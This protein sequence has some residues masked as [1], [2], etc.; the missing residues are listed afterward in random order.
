[1]VNLKYSKELTEENM[2]EIYE[3]EQYNSI[4]LELIAFL[5]ARNCQV[6]NIL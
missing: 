3:D 2:K 6:E 5:H 1:M 4:F